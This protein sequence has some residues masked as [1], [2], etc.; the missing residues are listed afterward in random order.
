MTVSGTTLKGFDFTEQRRLRK[1]DIQLEGLLKTRNG[2]L[3]KKFNLMAKTVKTSG[4]GRFNNS[5]IILKVV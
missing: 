2:Q 1:P 3:I 4:T 5:T